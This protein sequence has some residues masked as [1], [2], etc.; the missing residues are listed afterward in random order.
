MGLKMKVH[1]RLGHMQREEKEEIKVGEQ[2][3]KVSMGVQRESREI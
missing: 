2:G 3:K 1:N